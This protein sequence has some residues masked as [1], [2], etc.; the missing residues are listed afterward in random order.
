MLPELRDLVVGDEQ[1]IIEA[2]IP[3][4]Y[5]CFGFTGT[6]EL[7]YAGMEDFYGPGFMFHQYIEGIC[8]PGI[9][10]AVVDPQTHAISNAV[11]DLH[12]DRGYGDS[13]ELSEAESLALFIADQLRREVG[14]G[15]SRHDFRNP[16]AIASEIEY[17]AVHGEG[18]VPVWQFRI[19]ALDANEPYY[20][21]YRV[22]PEGRVE[23]G[24]RRM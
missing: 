20:D 1:Q 7:G 13:P 15:E 17:E 12:I 8:A 22:L 14:Y 3:G 19:R 23:G 21:E 9:F 2:V 16:D 11:G 4:V 5:K 24:I 18:L 6:E 10:F